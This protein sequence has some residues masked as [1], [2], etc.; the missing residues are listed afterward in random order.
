MIIARLIISSLVYV[1]LMFWLQFLKYAFLPAINPNKADRSAGIIEVIIDTNKILFIEAI[2][3][4]L[5]LYWINGFIFEP[6]SLSKP[7]KKRFNILATGCSFLFVLISLF[8][9]SNNYYVAMIRYLESN[10]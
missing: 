6:S 7:A 10:Q 4:A 9:F 5:L 3:G 8:V 1:V 2:A